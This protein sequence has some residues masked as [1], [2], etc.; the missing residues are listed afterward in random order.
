MALGPK[1]GSGVVEREALTC[2]LCQEEQEV[3]ADS[4]A[5]VLTACVQRSAVLTQCRGKVL[6]N[7]GQEWK[8]ENKNT[9]NSYIYENE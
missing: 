9:L 1:R 4:T 3:R 5:M 8:I 6:P 7:T 2:I